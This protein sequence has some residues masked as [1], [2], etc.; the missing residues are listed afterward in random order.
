MRS[1]EWVGETM[2]AKLLKEKKEEHNCSL[3]FVKI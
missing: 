3:W 2:I 1:G